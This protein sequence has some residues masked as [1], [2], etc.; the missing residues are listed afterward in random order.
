MV[1]RTQ[2]RICRRNLSSNR[3]YEQILSGRYDRASGENSINQSIK[4]GTLN[5]STKIILVIAKLQI[6]E[7]RTIISNIC[8]KSVDHISQLYY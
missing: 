2:N 3:F 4:Y 8:A 6:A 5:N 1:V 7:Y